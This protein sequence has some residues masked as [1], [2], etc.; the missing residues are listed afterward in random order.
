MDLTEWCGVQRRRRVALSNLAFGSGATY[1]PSP[2][3]TIDF[4][5]AASETP[6]S[7]DIVEGGVASTDFSIVTCGGTCQTGTE[8]LVGTSWTVPGRDDFAS[9][10]QCFRHTRNRET[11]NGMSRLG[12]VVW[13]CNLTGG[14]HPGRPPTSV[15]T[16]IRLLGQRLEYSNL[17]QR[18][19]CY[20]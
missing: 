12:I 6:A 18:R 4:G 17:Q 13:P 3:Q 2:D 11:A 7:F 20:R 16:L 9:P 10:G 15:L 8:S 5:F 14:C 19:S 1:L